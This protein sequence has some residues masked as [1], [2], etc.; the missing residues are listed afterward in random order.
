MAA[1]RPLGSIMRARLKAYEASS[2][3]RHTAEARPI[4][5][6]RSIEELPD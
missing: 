5:E 3:F 1:H 4:V 6:P 2:Q